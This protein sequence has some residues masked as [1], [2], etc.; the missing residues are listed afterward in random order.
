[1]ALIGV[2]TYRWLTPSSIVAASPG[3]GWLIETPEHISFVAA[4]LWTK[5]VKV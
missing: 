5:M 1:M 4:A 2:A 3:L